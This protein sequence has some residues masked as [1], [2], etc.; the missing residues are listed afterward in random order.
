MSEHKTLNAVAQIESLFA[1]DK[2]FFLKREKD[3]E[4]R[5]SKQVHSEVDNV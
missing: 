1:E 3:N 5:H 4:D 2:S